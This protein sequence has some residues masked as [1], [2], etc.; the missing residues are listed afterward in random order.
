MQAKDYPF[1]VQLSNTLDW[2]MT[3]N[4]F[5]FNSTVEPFGC[6]VLYNDLEKLGVAT[7]VIFDR[8]GWFGNFVIKE[9][10]RYKGAGSFLLKKIIS[11]L[12]NKGAHTIGLYSYSN[13]TDFYKKFGFKTD[14][15]FIV[16]QG[17]P[18][19]TFTKVTE[20][21]VAKKDNFPKLIKFDGVCLGFN[22]DK[23]LNLIFSRKTNIIY[24]SEQNNNPTGYIAA[25]I[26]DHQVE[27]GP[28]VVESNFR[29]VGI[30]LIAKAISNFS[31]YNVMIY[32]PKK[33]NKIIELLLKAGL[34][35]DT[36]LIRMFLG[37]SL[38]TDCLYFPES[39][40]RG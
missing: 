13:L 3:I 19:F 39:L 9:D 23:T 12:K 4:D 21:K 15:E 38:N 28:L 20:V 10:S 18:S 17:N 24:F 33:S 35:K 27:I 1:A 34:K 2:K 5:E 36:T 29:S 31:G 25:K 40:E 16:F 37:S 7:T 6:F 14:E 11:Y 32:V 26:Y 22:R 30:D 8:I